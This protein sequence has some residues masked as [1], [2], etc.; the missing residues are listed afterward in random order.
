M[1]RLKGPEYLPT[2]REIV[3]ECAAIRRHWTP[4]ERRR[5]SVGH[6]VAANVDRWS[7]PQI[8]TA[9]CLA[10]VRKIVADAI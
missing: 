1:S 6:G 5:R 2:R 10:R 9:H 4:S 3:E 7:P 8:L